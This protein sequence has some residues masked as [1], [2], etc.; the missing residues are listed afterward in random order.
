MWPDEIYW[1]IDLLYFGLL[2]VFPLIV[3]LMIF[4]GDVFS[5]GEEYE[6]Q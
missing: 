6:R 2:E 5:Q 3:M 1:W 4:K